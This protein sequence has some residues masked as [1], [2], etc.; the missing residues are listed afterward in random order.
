[1]SSTV[2]TTAWK[3]GQFRSARGPRKLLFGCMYEDV[4]IELRVFQPDGHI[5]CIASGGCTA[6]TLAAHHDVVAVDINPVQV[7]YVQ[8]RLG[9]RAIQ[10]GSAERILAFGRTLA[11]L[12]GWNRRA[13]RTFLDLDDPKQQIFYW[14]RHLDTRRFRAAFSLLF[15]R[16][17][18]R[19]LY[20]AAF[21]DG[22]P[23]NFGTVLRTRMERC[24]ALHPNRRN[25]YAHALLLGDMSIASEA[26]ALRQIEVRCA[27]AADFL[28]GQPAGSFSG[29]SLSNILDGANAAYTQRLLA[30][31]RHAA[32][33]E[34][35][36]VLRSFH[37]PE[38]VTETNHAAE[39]RSMLW[40]I[41]DVRP[42]ADA[43]STAG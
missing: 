38:C 23:P 26:P 10:R 20:S 37:E 43:A 21:L 6:V 41:V 42:A 18:L 30:A 2:P 25:P 22:L 31:V 27:D 35:T 3:H 15:S 17:V 16:R 5:F 12:A 14:R 32:A 33:P 28:E 11:P 1:M 4:G 13:V 34:A 8:Q 19:S 40:G 9:G 24:F 29:F 7:A 36:V 39:D